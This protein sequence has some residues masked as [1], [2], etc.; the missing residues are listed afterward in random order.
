MTFTPFTDPALARM[1]NLACVRNLQCDR[2]TSERDAVQ[3]YKVSSH[4]RPDF[5][6]TV[7]LYKD[8]RASCTCQAKDACTHVAVA[9]A[10][11]R[12]HFISEWGGEWR[13]DL[14]DEL[15]E[16]RQGTFRAGARKLIADYRARRQ[17]I[18]GARVEPVG[19]PF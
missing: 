15:I 4:S 19:S 7:L 3:V 12:P 18:V 16:M 10:D 9:L 1:H 17:A 11:Y 6:H 2:T 8:E 5:W 14:R 13:E